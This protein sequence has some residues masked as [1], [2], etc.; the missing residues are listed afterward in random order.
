MNPIFYRGYRCQRN[1]ITKQWY[2]FPEVDDTTER[3]IN[4]PDLSSLRIQIEAATTDM[5]PNPWE[6]PWAGE[7]TQAA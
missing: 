2:A 3:Q 5:Q 1:L 7:A 6:L 4:A